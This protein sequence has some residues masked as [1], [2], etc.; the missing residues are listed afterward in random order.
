MWRTSPTV[1][2]SWRWAKRI[3]RPI[4]DWMKRNFLAEGTWRLKPP[5]PKEE[6]ARGEG[7]AAATFGKAQISS[8]LDQALAG[9]RRMNMR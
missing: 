9:W 8:W 3:S 6:G 2:A 4:R 7:A 5:H 1:G